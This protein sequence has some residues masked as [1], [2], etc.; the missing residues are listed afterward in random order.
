MAD[1]SRGPRMSK[2]WLSMPSAQLPHTSN[3]TSLGGRIA[4]LSPGTVLRMLGE[5][6]VTNTGAVIAGDSAKMT[7]AVGVV[8]SDAFEAGQASVPDPAGEPEY[9]W[10]YWAEHTMYYP[11]T[12]SPLESANPAGALRR[13]IDIRSMRRIRPRESVCWIVQYADLAGTPPL[14]LDL[15]QTR[16]LIGLH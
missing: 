4:F 10:L 7:V 15:G 16:V 14:Q 1:R 3:A 2:A 5:Y 13:V 8:S 6:I 11:V 12:G 9:P